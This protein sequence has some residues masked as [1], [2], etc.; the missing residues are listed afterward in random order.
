MAGWMESWRWGREYFDHVR[1][2]VIRGLAPLRKKAETIPHPDLRA[3]ALSSLDTKQFHCEGGGVFGGP[4]RDP[5]GHLL[6]FLLPYQTLCDYL[7]T[8]TDRGPSTDPDNLRLLH[9]SLLDAISPNGPFHDYYAHHP[10]QDDGGYIHDLITRCRHAIVRFPGYEAVQP[11]MERLVSL[12][13]NLQVFKHGPEAERV[14]QL[15]RWWNDECPSGWA[16][17]WWEF[18]AATGSTLGLFALL[19]VAARPNPAP[20]T[21]KTVTALYFPWVGALHILLDYFIDQDEDRAGGDLNFV[22]YYPSPQDAVRRIR[23]IYRQCVIRA[24]SL[25][26]A[27][28]HRYVIR[29]LL[30]FYLADP[31]VRKKPSTLALKLLASGG[32][33]SFGVFLAAIMGRA[34]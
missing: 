21:V 26:D 3:Q 29:G 31:K 8:V 19:N 1:P 34:P 23:V 28:F 10:H 9:Q 6:D 24:A 33:V 20:E 5:S 2:D 7:D 12:Y 15:Q 27:S 30:G 17:D 18:A 4:S 11:T 22:T 13:I 16:I 25:S 32:S 14:S